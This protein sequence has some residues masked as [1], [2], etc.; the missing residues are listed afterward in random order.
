MV[1]QVILLFILMLHKFLAPILA[2]VLLV[3]QVN[4][5]NNDKIM[6]KKF[7]NYWL[8]FFL[9]M[10][11]VGD[12]VNIFSGALADNSSMYFFYIKM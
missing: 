3:P 2:W 10:F 6:K 11:I 1:K 12:T 9:G 4:I 7:L 5:N 8:I